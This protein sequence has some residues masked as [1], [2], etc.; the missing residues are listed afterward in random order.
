MDTSSML[1]LP[2][3]PDCFSRLLVGEQSTSHLPTQPWREVEKLKELK[4]IMLKTLAKDSVPCAKAL[5]NGDLGGKEDRD[6]E[7]HTGGVAATPFNR[8][9]QALDTL[10][11]EMVRKDP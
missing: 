2:P 5:F 9:N 6:S 8:L 4:D 11:K 1:D 7:A 3:V 10:K